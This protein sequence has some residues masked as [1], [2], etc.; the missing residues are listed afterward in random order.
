M[1]MKKGPKCKISSCQHRFDPAS[2]VLSI[3]GNGL[4]RLDISIPVR[5]GDVISVECKP[6]H[7]LL[8]TTA[9]KAA[10]DYRGIIPWSKLRAELMER[11]HHELRSRVKIEILSMRFSSGAT[12]RAGA[13]GQIFVDAEIVSTGRFDTGDFTTGALGKAVAD[14]LDLSPL[15]AL[16]S[17]DALISAFALLDKGLDQSTIFKI[18]THDHPIWAAFYRLRNSLSSEESTPKQHHSK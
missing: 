16:Q 2:R 10:F 8:R 5:Y 15:D 13:R 1:I 6:R 18:K 4:S 17:A 9:G 7:I 14:Y 3:S 11:T 12:G